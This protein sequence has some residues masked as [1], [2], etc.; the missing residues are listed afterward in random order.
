MNV[1][2]THDDVL[3]WT[4]SVA[5]EIG[6]M[7]VIMR[8]NTNIG[9]R[10]RT[11][12]VLIGCERSGQYRT[13][14]KDLDEKIIVSDM[15]KSM[16][17]R[18][19]LLTLKEHN[20]NSYTTIK[21][22]YNARNV[23]HSS[24]RDSTYK[25]NRYRMSLLDIVGVTP[26]RM[27]FSAAFAYLL[28]ST[29][30]LRFF[31]SDM[32]HSL[33]LLYQFVVS[34]SHSLVGKKNAWDYV[35][36][37]WGSLV[38]CPSEQEFD[39]F[40]MKFEIVCSPWPMFV[41]Y[42]KQTWLIPHKERF[43][44]AW[45]NKVESAHWALKRLLQ[46]SLGDLCTVWEAMNNMIT[47][48]HTKIKASFETSTH[49]VE[50]VFKVTLYK[51]L[52]G[53]VSRLRF[54][55]QRLSKL[56]VSIT[57]EMETITKRF[58]ELDV[59]GKVTLKIKLWE[60]SYPDLNSLCAPPKKVKTKGA[61]KQ[62]M[63]KHQRSTKLKRSASSSDQAKPRRIMPMLDQFHPRIHD[64]I[65]N[66]VDVKADG[67]CGY[68]AIVSLLVTM[69]K[70]MNITD[71]GYVIASKYNVILVSLSLQQSMTIFPLRSPPPTNC[72]VH[73]VICI[74]HVYGNHLVKGYLTT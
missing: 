21:Q 69:D 4:R 57:K 19:I 5:Y 33:K 59:Y 66:I 68:R 46:N 36:E 11:S 47:L 28:G 71:T 72:S 32:M 1:F 26:T 52:L 9:I 58:K 73:R 44:K 22:I 30:I 43:V 23:Y 34:I 54:S 60:I 31:S 27:T 29:T 51:K 65:E 64:S 20:A 62:P 13:K 10:G 6:F 24:I 42:V 39:D 14:K 17:T 15:T 49:V 38:D 74:V 25:T 35:M 55:D 3:D 50:H 48:R 7:A 67:N 53:M 12:F 8:S 63:T 41:D 56:E 70:W 18:N 37:A 40:L 2:A 61:Q 16:V 45:T